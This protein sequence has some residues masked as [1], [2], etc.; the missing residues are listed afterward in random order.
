MP[1]VSASLMG[2]GANLLSLLRVPCSG[3]IS[4]EAPETLCGAID[5]TSLSTCMLGKHFTHFI[6]SLDSLLFYYKGNY[7]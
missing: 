3:I 2:G 1:F 6:I 7:H 4:G 5:Q